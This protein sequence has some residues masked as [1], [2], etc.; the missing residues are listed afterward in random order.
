MAIKTVSNGIDVDRLDQLVLDLGVRVRVWKSTLC[1]NLTSLESNDHDINCKI[2]NRRMIDF[3][4]E[5]TMA[6]FQQQSLTEQFKV[7]GT[8][9][10]DEVMATFMSGIS[11]QTMARIDLLDFAE[12][13]YE[14]IQRR[15]TGD[16][17]KLKY[18][19]TC[20][21]GLFTVESDVKTEYHCGT[22]FDLD[23]NGNIKWSSAHRPS[24]KQIYSVYYKHAPIYRATKAVHRDRYSQPTSKSRAK[25]KVVADGKEF[26]KIGEEW[27]ISRDFF[28]DR[29][30]INGQPILPDPFYDPNE[31]TP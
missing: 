22:D 4:P 7:S 29:K 27:V 6:L 9:H 12:D 1:P 18:D 2:C 19:A 14:L 10:I 26:I 15:D 21:L 13:F 17:D 23:V 3:A 5:C 24:S 20:V 16:T 28:L 25:N 11:L 30:D 31:P 8:F